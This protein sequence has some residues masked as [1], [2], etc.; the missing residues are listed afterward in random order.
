MGTM[1]RFLCSLLF[2]VGFGGTACGQS[3]VWPEEKTAF[4]VIG[5]QNSLMVAALSCKA[6]H[7]YDA[8]MGKFQGVLQDDQGVMDRYFVRVGGLAGR[9]QE[10]AYMTQLANEQSGVSL[11]KGAAYCAGAATKFREVMGL[12]DAGTLAAFAVGDEDKQVAAM[13]VCAGTPPVGVSGQTVIAAAPARRA[14]GDVV[15]D[16]GKH[17]RRKAIVKAPVRPVTGLIQV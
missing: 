5:L 3:C 6:D 12:P 16:A 8:F 15:A 14:G 7:S 13:A 11:A 9:Q 10:D 17:A 4:E 1:T 2:V